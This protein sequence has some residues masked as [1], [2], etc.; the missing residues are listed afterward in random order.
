MPY[1]AKPESDSAIEL[2]QLDVS[3]RI[4]TLKA[5]K[6]EHLEAFEPSK[7]FENAN[8]RRAESEKKL[9]KVEGFDSIKGAYAAILCK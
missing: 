7:E 1:H 2:K 6:K 9:Q 4:E 3:A 8:D 5:K